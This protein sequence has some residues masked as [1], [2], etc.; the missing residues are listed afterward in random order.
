MRIYTELKSISRN[1]QA[2]RIL[3]NIKL[4]TNRRGNHCIRKVLKLGITSDGDSRDIVVIDNNPEISA[5]R[6]SGDTIFT[7]LPGDEITKIITKGLL[8]FR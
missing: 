8:E 7:F 5:R 4:C 1:V 6:P 2:T 3:I